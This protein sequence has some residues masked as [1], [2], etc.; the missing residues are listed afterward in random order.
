MFM[1]SLVTSCVLWA[2]MKFALV[3]HAI[4]CNTCFRF[5]QASFFPSPTCLPTNAPNK[6]GF[7]SHLSH[8]DLS[9]HCHLPTSGILGFGVPYY[10]VPSVS[11]FPT[12]FE[13]ARVIFR[14]AMSPPTFLSINF[15]L[16]V[17][18]FVIPRSFSNRALLKFLFESL[19]LWRPSYARGR[20]CTRYWVSQS[21][22]I[23]KQLV[24]LS[25]RTSFP[26]IRC[27]TQNHITSAFN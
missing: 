4:S 24:L 7:I 14:L 9:A 10:P 22:M 25:L 3:N 27:S 8:P 15:S 21:Q 18:C 17:S 5:Y 11:S 2:L 20:N 13:S 26:S 23:R 6:P 1:F 19:W 16:P 12:P